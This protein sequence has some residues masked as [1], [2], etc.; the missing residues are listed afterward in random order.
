MILERLASVETKLQKLD[1]VFEKFSAL[2]T[3]VKSMQTKVNTLTDKANTMKEKVDVIDKG[4]DFANVEIEGLK[5]KDRENEGKIKELEDKFLY[6]EVYNRRE[7]LRFFGI[8][9]AS[10]GAE[11]TFEVMHR[12]FSEE[13]NIVNTSDIS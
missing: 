3:T 7:N 9:E 4:M 8:P 12:F 10:Q 11:D 6:Q 13:L 1:E 5:K 2:E